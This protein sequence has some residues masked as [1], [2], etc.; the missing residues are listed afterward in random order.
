MFNISTSFCG[1]VTMKCLIAIITIYIIVVDGFATRTM[2]ENLYRNKRAG[3]TV[4]VQIKPNGG[5][6]NEPYL[7]CKGSQY[8]Q[9]QQNMPSFI[10]RNVNHYPSGLYDSNYHHQYDNMQQLP[11]TNFQPE[12]HQSLPMAYTHSTPNLV[13]QFPA[14]KQFQLQDHHLPN[15]VTNAAAFSNN[16]H[17]ETTPQTADSTLPEKDDLV[18]SLKPTKTLPIQ[19]MF[20]SQKNIHPS[21]ENNAQIFAKPMNQQSFST[22]P[23]Q[24]NNERSPSS[25]S[26]GAEK[27]NVGAEQPSSDSNYKSNPAHYNALIEDEVLGAPN[28]EYSPE[29][30]SSLPNINR[31]DPNTGDIV[32]TA[33][34]Y[35]NQ[36]QPYVPSD[37]LHDPVLRSF[38]S[39]DDRTPTNYFQ[40]MPA[41]NRDYVN[42]PL[43]QNA[44]GCSPNQLP[45]AFPYLTAPSY[46]QYGSGGYMER[47]Q[48][49]YTGCDSPCGFY[50]L[51]YQ[52][53]FIAMPWFAF[54]YNDA[55]ANPLCGQAQSSYDSRSMNLEHG[56][57]E[58]ALQPNLGGPILGQANIEN[59]I[60]ALNNP[61]PVAVNKNDKPQ[62]IMINSTTD[63]SEDLS[64][65]EPEKSD[66]ATKL[67]NSNLGITPQS[68]E[69]ETEDDEAEDD[70][71]T[72]TTT[73]M[74]TTSAP[75]TFKTMMHAAKMHAQMAYGPRRDNVPLPSKRQIPNYATGHPMNYQKQYVRQLERMKF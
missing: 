28:F 35:D 58:G 49:S 68:R 61:Q 53:I 38:Y 26:N 23:R 50:P 36:Q 3:T 14:A 33:Q 5:G 40:Q 44:N 54:P 73:V 59:P 64:T 45:S 56:T 27:Y 57:L 2:P 70:D 55:L 4:C 32:G 41:I 60:D 63:S 15:S 48:N 66:N 16:K 25:H 69:S 13:N 21:N 51:S 43:P 71:G 12:Y 29:E 42:K 72:T 20:E 9:R 11:Y 22:N 1:F 74:P 18:P 47:L 46:S 24:E 67:D 7:M 65:E 39:I 10:N 19:S 34:S 30:M 31:E 37:Y 62:D 17:F 75:K 6:N 52:P 8:P